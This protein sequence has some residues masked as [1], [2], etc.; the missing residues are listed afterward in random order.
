MKYNYAI[1]AMLG[2]TSAWQIFQEE[3]EE[4]FL[5]VDLEKYVIDGTAKGAPLQDDYKC[6]HNT[7]SG[8]F[9]LANATGGRDADTRFYDTEITGSWNHPDAYTLSDTWFHFYD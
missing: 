2:L 7:V 3:S 5:G 9:T 4:P 8:E 6:I 1:A